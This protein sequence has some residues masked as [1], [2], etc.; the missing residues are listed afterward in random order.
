MNLTIFYTYKYNSPLEMFI[1]VKNSVFICFCR[2]L[3]ARKRKQKHAQPWQKYAQTDDYRQPS[4]RYGQ[5]SKG[6]GNK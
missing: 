5:S 4:V 3:E 2:I 6:R 1:Q